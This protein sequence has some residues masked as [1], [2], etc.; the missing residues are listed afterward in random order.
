MDEKDIK[1][2]FRDWMYNWGYYPN[3]LGMYNIKLDSIL[4]K[5]K[6]MIPHYNP[7]DYNGSGNYVVVDDVF[8]LQIHQKAKNSPFVFEDSIIPAHIIFEYKGYGYGVHRLFSAIGQ[9]IVYY[10]L[11][12]Q[13]MYLVIDIKDY[14][15]LESIFTELPFGIICYRVK[16]ID[17][18]I[19][20]F[21]HPNIFPT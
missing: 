1:V 13:P 19:K 11:I 5:G 6:L 4:Q 20:V 15:I 2:L 8:E 3:G 17:D 10:Y 21:K 16:N 12:K 9:S 18:G 14:L 7:K